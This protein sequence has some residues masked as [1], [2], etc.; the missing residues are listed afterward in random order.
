MS[1][2]LT[3]KDEDALRG[4]VIGTA[5][6]RR[7]RTARRHS[8]SGPRT[9]TARTLKFPNRTSRPPRT[10]GPRLRSFASLKDRLWPGFPI[11]P[12]LVETGS[13]AGT[14]NPPYRLGGGSRGAWKF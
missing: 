5:D 13:P 10:V 6:V 9:Y 8:R 2:W 1:R 12:G 7:S 14:E 3:A 11:P 4:S